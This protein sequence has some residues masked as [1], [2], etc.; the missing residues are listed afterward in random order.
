MIAAPSIMAS[1]FF[2]SEDALAILQNPLPSIET[3]PAS[4]AETADNP[5]AKVTPRERAVWQ[6]RLGL[7]RVQTAA[8]SL[9][10][11]LTA[12]FLMVVF[13][14]SIVSTAIRALIAG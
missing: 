9:L 2:S 4:G 5:T 12:V 7:K 10:Q 11:H 13:S 8:R 6:E 1:G 14:G 3:T